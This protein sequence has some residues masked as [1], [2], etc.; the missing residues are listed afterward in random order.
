MASASLQKI[1]REL[2]RTC[3]EVDYNKCRECRKYKVVNEE[4]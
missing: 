4:I 1:S 2:C 3:P